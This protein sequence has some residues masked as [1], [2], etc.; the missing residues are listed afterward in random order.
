MLTTVSEGIRGQA[1]KSP[2][3]HMLESR[4]FRVDT[5]SEKLMAAFTKLRV[6]FDSLG[7]GVPAEIAAAP[8]RV[9][10]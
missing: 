3:K 8:H 10:M 4:P 9:D 5:G 7:Y 6:E 1:E 2:V